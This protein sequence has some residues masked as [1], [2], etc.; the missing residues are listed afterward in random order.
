[1][2]DRP[3]PV[4]INQAKLNGTTI[5]VSIGGGL[6]LVVGVMASLV[7]RYSLRTERDYNSLDMTV[8]LG[9]PIPVAKLTSLV[10][11]KVVPLPNEFKRLT[12]ADRAKNVIVKSRDMGKSKMNA[13]LNR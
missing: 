12:D 6:I 11:R 4:L 5:I 13:P 7:R 3:D 10:Q 2:L 1:M 8:D 9:Q